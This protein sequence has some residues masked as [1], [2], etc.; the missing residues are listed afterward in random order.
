MESGTG[1][2]KR[3]AYD[4]LVVCSIVIIAAAALAIHF[5][6][7]ARLFPDRPIRSVE[8][9]IAQPTT[10]RMKLSD[11]DSIEAY[12]AQPLRKS[13]IYDQDARRILIGFLAIDFDDYR[14]PSLEKVPIFSPWGYWELNGVTWHGDLSL[15]KEALRR[16]IEATDPKSALL[17]ADGF[18]K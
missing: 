2:R 7:P 1:S 6:W 15:L 9:V 5:V 10:Y 18:W 14:S 16:D 8:L 11:L 12:V 3:I 4:L 17:R 13:T